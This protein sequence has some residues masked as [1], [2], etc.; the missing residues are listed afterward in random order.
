MS[1]PRFAVAAASPVEGLRVALSPEQVQHLRVLRLK[2]GAALEL[3]LADGPWRA[4]L[5][6]LDRDRA[7]VRLV[8]PVAEDREAPVA[9]D[10]YLPLT[11]QLSLVDELLPPLVELG[12]TRLLP[13]AWARSEYDARRTLARFERWKR[14]VAVAAEQSHRSR[15]PI[16]EAPLPF[17]ALLGCDAPQ[18]W[19]AYEGRVAA[20]PA[21]R[22]EPIALASGPEGGVTDEEFD[23]LVAAGWTP[24]TLGRGILRA[25]TAPVALLGAVGYLLSP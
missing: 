15:L 21:P 14:I 23:R 6:V 10:V 1:L 22:R 9:I 4:D 18:R 7:E 25:A 3:L 16:L 12:A 8:A 20:N 24:V 5:A 17:E 19:L 11:A 13:T 2:P